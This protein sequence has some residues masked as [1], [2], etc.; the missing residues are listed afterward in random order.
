MASGGGTGGGCNHYDDCGKCKKEVRGSDNGV[1]CDWCELWYHAGCEG[2]QLDVYRVL[3]R[4]KDQP[5]YCRNY[6]PLMRNM[7][8]MN[9]KLFQ[10]NEKMKQRIQEGLGNLKREVTEDVANAV[11][12]K[13]KREITTDM[14]KKMTGRIE[15][16]EEIQ[17]REKNLVIYNIP[18]SSQEQT[19]ERVHEDVNKC[20]KLIQD[21]LQVGGVSFTKVIRIGKKEQGRNRPILLKMENKE[22]KW[23]ALSKAKNLKHSQDP[24]TKKIGISPDLTRNQR[25]ESKKEW[26]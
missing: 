6:R 16:I 12:R 7:G 13:M 4:N 14:T 11:L 18:E 10:E 20:K 21:D 26:N 1:R 24:V 19:E 2:V 9:E 23:R 5:W 8:K 22:D 17:R 25:E 3:Q 15:E